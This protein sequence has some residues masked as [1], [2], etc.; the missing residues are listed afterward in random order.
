[1]KKL[2]ESCEIWD[3]VEHIGYSLYGTPEEST[4]FKFAEALQKSF[5]IV[6]GVTDKNY[7]TNSYHVPV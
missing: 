3:S 5:G 4:T 7:V 6:K 2:K 1:M